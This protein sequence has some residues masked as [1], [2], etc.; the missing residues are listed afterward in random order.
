MSHPYEFLT[1]N[2]LTSLPFPKLYTSSSIS[3]ILPF[4]QASLAG[5]S[6]LPPVPQSSQLPQSPKFPCSS[7]LT[8][9]YLCVLLPLL[10]LSSVRVVDFHPRQHAATTPSSLVLIQISFSLT[11]FSAHTRALAF[12]DLFVCSF[13]V[14]LDC[15]T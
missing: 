5:P 13:S 12:I 1:S 11:H 3:H 2:V 14:D 7:A 10:P 4:T 9:L 6:S 15:G 8:F